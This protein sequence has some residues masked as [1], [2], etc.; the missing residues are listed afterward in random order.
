MNNTIDKTQIHENICKQMTDT[1]RR[2]NSDYGD[3]FAKLRAE[4]DNAILIRIYDKYSRLK[5]LKSGN[6]VQQVS[7]ES[8]KDTLLDLA[9]YCIL[10]LV[11][12]EI[13][14]RNN[15]VKGITNND[16]E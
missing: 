6:K 4:F 10:E 9:N 15:V 7:D 3:S 16:T 8:I 5:S 12:M 13:D 2:K 11:E 1:Y 14:E